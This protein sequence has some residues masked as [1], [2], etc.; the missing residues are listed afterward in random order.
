MKGEGS[1]WQSG[2][3][4]T[5]LYPTKGYSL[6]PELRTTNQLQLLTHLFH[7]VL[8]LL[9]RSSFQTFCHSL[10]GEAFLVDAVNGITNVQEVF[11]H[12]QCLLRKERQKR[13]LTLFYN[14]QFRYYLHLFTLIFRQLGVNLESTDRVYIITKKINTIWK[15]TTI[16]IDIKNAASQGKLS[17]LIDIV[18]LLKSPFTQGLGSSISIQH[19]PLTKHQ[20]PIIQYFLRNNQFS[21]SLWIGNDEK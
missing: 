15:L 14:S 12:H 8:L 4:V 10:L 21:Y 2:R 19:V 20:R 13:H 9:F 11:H 16:G 18:N 5:H 7:K 1:I 17:W 6:T 3:T